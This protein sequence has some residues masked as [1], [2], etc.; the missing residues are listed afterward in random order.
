MH[1]FKLK[2]LNKTPAIKFKILESITKKIKMRYYK[3]TCQL[4]Q[5]AENHRTGPG[6]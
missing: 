1:I 5:N 3:P 2:V 6:L 4:K